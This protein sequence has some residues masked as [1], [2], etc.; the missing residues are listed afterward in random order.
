M[1]NSEIIYIIKE[2]TDKHHVSDNTGF[3][4]EQILYYLLATRAKLLHDKNKNGRP[5]STTNQMSTP[6]INLI[7]AVNCPCVIP[8]DCI[9][10]MT[11]R[12]IPNSIG[13]LISVSNPY[14]NVEYVKT[15]SNLAKYRSKNRFDYFN[16][17][18]SYFEN[19]ER[20]GKRIFIITKKP[21]KAI[22]TTFIP[23]NPEEVYRM[24]DCNG[25]NEY[26]CVSSYDLPWKLDPDLTK[27]C[28]DETINILLRSRVQITDNRND[29]T[30]SN[31]NNKQE[32]Y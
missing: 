29:N 19:D 9:P 10:L 6:C 4:D 3:S 14:D 28:I 1:L 21:L 24:D 32:I 23:E 7:P 12:I 22:R 31:V 30:D 15:K 16:D 11:E 5:I 2:Q 27:I 20:T 8:D 13:E 18:T 17:S 26:E 25:H